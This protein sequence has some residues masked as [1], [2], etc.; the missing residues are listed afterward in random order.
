MCCMADNVNPEHGKTPR[1]WIIKIQ[2]PFGV[3][4]ICET[5]T[6]GRLVGPVCFS[7]GVL[8]SVVKSDSQQTVGKKK[9]C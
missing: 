6:C 5:A 2:N 7:F 1:T 3:G 8:L 4:L 9:M